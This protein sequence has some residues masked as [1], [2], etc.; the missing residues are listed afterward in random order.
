LDGPLVLPDGVGIDIASTVLY[1][2]PFPENLNGTDFAPAILLTSDRPLDV[3]LIGAKP[4]TVDKAAA[5]LR[6]QDSRHTVRVLGHGYLSKVE[7]RLIL[8]EIRKTPL[9]VIFVAKGN[10]QQEFWIKENADLSVCTVAVGVGALFDFLAGNV[11]RAPT[12]IRK[13]RFEWAFRLIQEPRRLAQRYLMGN[14]LFLWRVL[15][16]K[17]ASY[18]T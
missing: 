9:D 11:P 8:N 4:G 5:A 14:G 6:L 18:L 3:G 1:G 17:L 13:L 15:R 10:P 12:L 7:E 2:A 16:V